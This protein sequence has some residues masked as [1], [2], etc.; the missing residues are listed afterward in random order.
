MAIRRK[1]K[2]R[3]TEVDVQL[4]ARV[5]ARRQLLG[6]SQEELGQALGVTFQQVQ[7][8]ER[9][10][11]CMT[12]SRLMDASRVLNTPFDFFVDGVLPPTSRASGRA[13]HAQ[14]G[15][16]DTR[17]EGFEGDILTRRET[18][19]LIRAYYS[20]RDEKL[21]RQLLEMARAMASKD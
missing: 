20:I 5:R 6:L 8:Y 16:A 1:T 17:Q 10:T 15:F 2:A 19:D 11:N 4:G 12:V 14:P 9:G 13:V 7:K 3:A 21:R 18:M